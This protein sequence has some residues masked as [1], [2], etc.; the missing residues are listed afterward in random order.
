MS[1]PALPP[2]PTRDEIYRM[3][4]GVLAG[5]LSDAELQ[6]FEQLVTHDPTACDW[7]VEFMCDVYN[8][9]TNLALGRQCACG[10]PLA[11]IPACGSDTESEATFVGLHS[12]LISASLHATTG[13]LSSGWPLAYLIA[14]VIL[15][16]GLV[17]GA[18]TYVS[19]PR[20]I[21]T[22]NSMPAAAV[23]QRAVART[24]ATANCRWGKGAGPLRVKDAVPIGRQL[25]LISGLLEITYDTGA[26]VILQGPVT[27]QVESPAGGFLSI[28]KL[29][30]SVE[31]AASQNPSQ[32]PKIRNPKSETISKSQT[33][34]ISKYVVR[35]PTA[36]VT[37]LGTEFGVE[38]SKEGIT[39]S[40]VFCGTIRVE[41]LAADG[42]TRE[43]GRVLHENESVR[44]ESSGVAARIVPVPSLMASAAFVREIPKRAIHV[45]D[46]VDVVA[47]GDGFG[48]ARG[49]GIDPTSG[50]IVIQ[51][52][53][54]SPQWDRIRD[55]GQYHRVAGIPFV[56]GVF[57]PDDSRGPV[58]LDSAGH[59]FDEFKTSDD[60]VF[61]QIW[62]GGPIPTPLPP[63]METTV[64]GVDYASPG[65]GVLGMVSNKGIT[66]D[67]K[68]IRLADPD[69][70]ILR[71]RAWAGN[72][73]LLSP[74]KKKWCS[75]DIRI[76]VDGQRRFSQLNVNTSNGIA[77]FPVNVPID[78][79]DRFLTLTVTDA[80]N[81]IVADRIIFGDPRL[82]LLTPPTRVSEA[83]LPHRGL[84]RRTAIRLFNTGVDAAVGQPD[85]HWQI[86]AAKD[87]PRFQPRA[88]IV[89]STMASQLNEEWLPNEPG[90]S[91]W[92]SLAGDGTPL[93]QEAGC[94]FRTSFEIPEGTMPSTAELSGCFAADN[95][96]S[97]MRI[98]GHAAPVPKHGH[99]DYGVLRWFSIHRGFVA[100]TNS[101]E[102]DVTNDE[103]GD[104]HPA[105]ASPMGLRV[106]L[107]GSV[108]A[109]PA[110]PQ[111]GGPETK[112][113]Q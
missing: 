90:R 33:L 47:G 66:F 72:T 31:N 61:G 95:H 111:K 2:N 109:Q 11:A 94:T 65:H 60:R 84:P 12:P 22:S 71:F 51:P 78:D 69:C 92:I 10:S 1:R 73:H 106:E 63:P 86:V 23:E 75:A 40:H 93:P 104:P 105:I 25:S 77:W 26:K 112:P 64:A 59:T 19:E 99:R 42:R 6:R 62:A 98:N 28:G 56:D 15:G 36:V 18:F 80:G 41:P 32:K 55:D 76:F 4:S 82:E 13:Y 96:V 79:N 83:G 57:V 17:I 48:H 58:Q 113:K 81:S 35:T 87:D 85:P 110:Q 37:D 44:V 38:V 30:A 21:V 45:L 14:T 20:Q 8:L 103:P 9:H 43:H 54:V 108:Q 29:T 67:L 100:G 34:Q 101:L 39:T 7:Y 97:A 70:R 102:I 5:D 74:E 107:R 89:S 53:S 52:P 3:A 91:Q 27:Y 24:T 49:R 16:V 50:A 46:L 68:A 88:A